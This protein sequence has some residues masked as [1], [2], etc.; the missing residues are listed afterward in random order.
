V[1]VVPDWADTDL[2]RPGE[3]MNEFRAA[4]GLENQFV[5][6]F[7]GIMGW[8]QGL[9]TVVE[10]A[11]ILVD[12]PGLV[13]LLVGDGVERDGLER[14]AAGL[15]NVRFLPMQSKDVYPQVL[16]ACDVGLVTLRPEVATPVVPSKICTIMAAERPV[17]ASLPL[18]GDA[19]R[20]IIDAQCGLVVP[21]GDAQALASAVLE[22]K[23]NQ[24]AAQEMGRHGRLYAEKHLSRSVCIQQMQE[25]LRFAVNAPPPAAGAQAVSSLNI[26]RAEPADLDAIVAVHMAAFHS[27]FTMSALG[28]GFL[29]K[30]YHV[31]LN[32]DRGIL[33][34]AEM[35]GRVVGFVAGFISPQRFYQTMNARKWRFALPIIKALVSRPWLVWRVLP[36]L[37]RVLHPVR[38]S[39][40]PE[41]IACELASIAVHP[42]A[43]RQ[44]TGRA[45]VREFI[46]ASRQNKATELYLTTDA[47]DNARTNMFYRRLGFQFTRCYSAPGPRLMNEYLFAVDAESPPE[48]AAAAEFP[49][50][51]HRENPGGT[52]HHT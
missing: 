23:R 10:A 37:D 1:F 14:Q 31:I 42:A 28:L 34:V 5:V 27:R 22:L 48:A 9:S 49:H 30:Y 21:A 38:R 36:L 3:R 44:G 32:Y 40:K 24:P 45:L 11:R 25:V 18:S 7:A 33:L 16:E 19:P 8:S 35:Q 26:C 52:S 43:S 51:A 29:R 20:L 4:N 12:E 17:I 41:T 2:I 15:A 13:F 50:L 46:R 6:L 47:L 39:P